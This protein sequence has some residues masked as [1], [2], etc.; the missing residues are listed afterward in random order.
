[1]R[2]FKAKSL[3]F[4]VLMGILILPQGCHVGR[5]VFWNYADFDDYEKF[6]SKSIEGTVKKN[7]FQFE[8]NQPDKAN[9]IAP[10]EIEISGKKVDFDQFL[11]NRGTTAFLVLRSDTIYYEKYLNGYSKGDPMPS[12]SVAKSFISALMGIAIEEGAV[13]QVSDPITKYIPELKKQG[14]QEV[15][16]KHLLNMRSG[17]EFSENYQNPFS[18]VAK[19]YYGRNL[20]R[21][22]KQLEVVNKPG[23][24]TRYQSGNTQLLAW[25][26][27][28]ATGQSVTEY[29]EQKI[30]KPIGA[31]E[32]SWSI[33]SEKHG[34]EKA[35]CCLNT[36]ARNFA[37]FGRLYRKNGIWQGDT[38][39]PPDW[40]NI[41][42]R[43]QSKTKNFEYFYHWW[44]CINTRVVADDYDS[45]L[46]GPMKKLKKAKNQQGEV[47]QYVVVP[48]APFYAKGFMGQYIY[49]APKKDLIILRFGKRNGNFDWP[50]FFKSYVKS[51]KS[52]S[53]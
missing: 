20:K 52:N 31:K 11:K 39:V 22:L 13:D 16:L 48:C 19:F 34:M 26:L 17:I 28:R 24:K 4:L 40:V 25:V 42:T 12:F 5:M 10:R 6:P 3:A 23:M 21:F 43:I 53:L 2:P 32:A 36:T 35:F 45:T 41:S 47:K 50:Y 7:P 51:L 27:E 8:T 49:I 30:W 29:L 9:A 44:H 15:T 37:R 18:E 46:V 14:F 38:I 1:M 33:D